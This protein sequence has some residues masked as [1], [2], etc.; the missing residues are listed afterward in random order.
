MI[1]VNAVSPGPIVTPMV[2]S[3]GM[4]L[5]EEQVEQ[6]K[7]SVLSRVPPGRMGNPE[8]LQKPSPSLHPMTAVISQVSNYSSMGV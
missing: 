8:K 2:S 3:V 4:G 1:R 5:S 6:F 7:K